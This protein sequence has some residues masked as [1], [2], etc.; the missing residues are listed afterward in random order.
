MKMES[1][2]MALAAL[3]QDTRLSIFRALVRAHSQKDAEGGLAAGELADAL[4]VAPATL[5]FHLKEL[6]H[7]G[8]VTSRREGRSIIY[9]ANL[10]IME[11][12]TNYL[13][14]DCC[15]G[16]CGSVAAGRRKMECV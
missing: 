7:A 2:I 14:E 8:L 11:G 5:S 16:A 4:G 9:K 12:L 3:A 15:Q 10:Q 6:S 13:L 1:A